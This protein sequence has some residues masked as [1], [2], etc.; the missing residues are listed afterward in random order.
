MKCLCMALAALGAALGLLAGAVP[1]RVLELRSGP[2]NP[3]NSE[4]DFIR[5]KDGRV[6]FVYSH[7]TKGTGGDHDPRIS[8]R[9]F[10][11]TVDA[12]GRSS[13]SKSWRTTAG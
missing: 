2:G 8:A 12:P 4:G 7:Y 13:R 1:E 11:P 6:L 9:A 5:L 3:R 10:P